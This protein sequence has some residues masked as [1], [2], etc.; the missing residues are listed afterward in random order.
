ML[1]DGNGGYL[2]NCHVKRDLFYF[3]IAVIIEKI[4]SQWAINI[5]S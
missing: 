4:F 1:I 3:V 2:I 5:R